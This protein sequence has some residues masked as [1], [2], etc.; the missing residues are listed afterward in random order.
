MAL[1]IGRP[2]R[3]YSASFAV[4]PDGAVYP[5]HACVIDAYGTLFDI[6]SAVRRCGQQ[7]GGKAD[8]VVRNWRS[9]QLDERA[10]DA[11]RDSRF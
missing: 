7:L 11:D 6:S 9:K 2:A 4:K 5:V 3:R 10:A 1:A 8:A